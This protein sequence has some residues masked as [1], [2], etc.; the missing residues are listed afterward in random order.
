MTTFL[1]DG[2]MIDRMAQFDLTEGSS[3]SERKKPWLARAGL[4][5]SRG[6]WSARAC[7]AAQS[8][9][10]GASPLSAKAPTLRM[11]LRPKR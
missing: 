11:A 3:E 6:R 9:Q 1:D 4:R 7:A 8:R 10:C 2:T 5:K